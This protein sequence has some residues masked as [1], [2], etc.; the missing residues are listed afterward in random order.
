[1]RNPANAPPAGVCPASAD[2]A[3]TPGARRHKRA[4]LAAAL[5]KEKEESDEEEEE[6]D[7]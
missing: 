5:L 4:Q 6:D 3:A 2:R 1:M 7:L